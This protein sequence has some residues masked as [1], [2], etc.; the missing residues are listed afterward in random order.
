MSDA[1]HLDILDDGTFRAP[2]KTRDVLA[3]CAGEY[4]VAI[5]HAPLVTLRRTDSDRAVL[6]GGEIT[7]KTTI[8]EI[9]NFLATSGW[10]GEFQIYG[11]HTRLLR[12]DQ[13]ALKAARSNAPDERLGEVLFQRGVLT[14]EEV[15]MVAT[16]VGERRFGE[17]CVERGLI[18]SGDLYLN[19]Q[20]QSEAIFYGA[21]LEASGDFVVLTSPDD[22][23][24]TLHIPVQALLM[25]G[26]QR[27]DEMALFRD[28]I[29]SS[30]CIVLPI[31]DAKEPKELTDEARA[32]YAMADGLA[33]LDDIAR[34]TGY[35]EFV[36]TKAVYA[37]LKEKQ[38]TVERPSTV[39]PAAIR[40]LVE[41]FNEVLQDVFIAVA[42]YGGL[43]RARGTL[44]AW[45]QG[46]GYGAFFGESLDEFG[47]IDAEV[48]VEAFSSVRVPI[49]PLDSLHQALHELSAFA[50]FTA[51]T[52]LPRD[53]E[54]ALAR[55]VNA[56]LK[57]IRI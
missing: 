37:L 15:D 40:S 9:S 30:T 47:N 2:A 29:P 55:D 20:K 27:I 11:E 41:R 52:Q 13:G 14:R 34:R 18:D 22:D 46:S 33:S 26:V 54:L 25:E 45:I 36:T 39:D 23:A 4:Q 21:L 1:K 50:L 35:G 8:M 53:Q 17:L 12:I 31:H 28:L 42:T 48:V 16:D 57:A 56:R 5:A 7:S 49:D 51:T 3:R 38:V 6:I 43:D 19:L 24:D 10:R 32:V 44:E